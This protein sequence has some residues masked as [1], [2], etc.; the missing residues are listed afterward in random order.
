M[1][2]G[3]LVEELLEGLK[4]QKTNRDSTEKTTKSINLDL[5]TARD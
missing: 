1:E 2:L 3:N 4:D 5:G